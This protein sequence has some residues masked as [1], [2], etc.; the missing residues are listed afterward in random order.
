M[1]LVFTRMPGESYHRWLRS[2]LLCLCCVFQALINSLV[3]WFLPT[4]VSLGWRWWW[5]HHHCHHD[6]HHL[7]YIHTVQLP[8]EETSLM[9]FCWKELA[10]LRDDLS[11]KADSSQQVEKMKFKSLNQEFCFKM[12]LLILL[13]WFSSVTVSGTTGFRKHCQI[14]QLAWCLPMTSLVLFLG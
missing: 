14:S 4:C 13:V 8:I 7:H 3:C 11:K 5:Y 10:F 6:S 2:L 9:K 1:Y 12:P